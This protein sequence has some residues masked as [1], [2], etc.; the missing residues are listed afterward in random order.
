MTPKEIARRATSIFRRAIPPSWAI[1]DQQDQ[2]DYGV[3]YE[4]EPMAA[5]DTATGVLFKVQ[6]KGERSLK[7]DSDG[8]QVRLSGFPV[9]RLRYLH[10]LQI[11]VVIVAVDVASEFVY[12]VAL[13][14][15]RLIETLLQEAEIAGTATLTL[16]LPIAHTI[17]ATGMEMLQAVVHAGDYIT[18]R[19]MTRIRS[20]R[21]ARVA[22][23]HLGVTQVTAHMRAHCDLLRCHELEL[24]LHSGSPAEVTA[25]AQQILESES[26]SLQMRVAAALYVVK[27]ARVD[28]LSCKSA[29]SAGLAV[30]IGR[31]MARRLVQLTRHCRGE[32]RL[33]IVALLQGRFAEL[34]DAVE[35]DYAL[36]ISKQVLVATGDPLAVFGQT[37]MDL[38]RQQVAERVLRQAGGIRHLL[39]RLVENDQFQ[40]LP[41]NWAIFAGEMARFV[42]RMRQEGV[43]PSAIVDGL[44]S[45]GKIA[46]DIACRL[47]QW[48][49]V[50][51]CA[52]ELVMLGLGDTVSVRERVAAARQFVRQIPPGEKELHE[53]F[54]F[55]LDQLEKQFAHE[56]HE[57]PTFEQETRYIERMARAMGINLDN[58]NDETAEIVRIGL[59][60]RNP[61]R[62]LRTCRHLYLRLAG[63]GLPGRM[64]GLPTAGFKEL[65]C[66]KFGHGMGGLRLDELFGLFGE[67][68]CAGCSSKDVH[69]PDW[70]WSVEWQIDQD[71]ANAG[72]VKGFP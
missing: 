66:T 49:D 44:D 72:Q 48:G 21:L 24:L 57:V 50:G 5:D 36:F 42:S 28:A 30:D 39:E 27:V 67:S 58:V 32:R 38:R 37:I 54:G 8:S 46:I 65:H 59:K 64:L 11:P 10:Q 17:S 23:D 53:R 41:Q 12:W 56:I 71:K 51:F 9:C 20:D 70:K 69:A 61:E 16:R 14:G 31:G 45:I 26:E 25:R 2:E 62:V 29:E 60:D 15:N 4:I 19:S 3:D 34:Q 55:D 63:C 43:N 40:L 47:E 68:F 33:R 35:Q 18:A 7:K 22:R 6:Q 52:T 1:R 13:Q